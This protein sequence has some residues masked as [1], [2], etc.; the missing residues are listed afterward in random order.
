[1]GKNHSLKDITTEET[2]DTPT[3]GDTP[4]WYE[5]GSTSGKCLMIGGGI[6]V[7]GGVI[8]AIFWKNIANWWNGPAEEE[9]QGTTKEDEKE[10]ESE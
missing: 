2:P 6:V 1:M 5:W 9:G 8:A 7:L 10:D 3:N 4:K